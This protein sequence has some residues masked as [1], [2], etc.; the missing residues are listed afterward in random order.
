MGV[1]Y[2]PVAEHFPLHRLQLWCPDSVHL[3]DSDGM[4][5]LVQLLWDAASQ[6][7]APPPPRP[8]A[9]PRAP[10]RAG[11]APRLVV[12]GHAPVPRH[13]DP[14]EWS[15]VGQGGKAALP[16]RPSAIPSNPV[17]FSGAMLDAMEKVSPSSGSDGGP[18]V[19]P[20]GRTSRVVRRPAGVA[21]RRRGAKRQV[22]ATPS[23]APE[24]IPASRPSPPVPPAEAATQEVVEEVL[25]PTAGPVPA[26]VG[27]EGPAAC[28]ALPAERRL[29]PAAKCPVPERSRSGQSGV[30]VSAAR[31]AAVVDVGT[32]IR[33]Q[34]VVQGSFHQGSQRFSNAG[35]Q[36][37]SVAAF[38]LARHTLN[39]VFLWGRQDLDDVLVCGDALYTTA[40]SRDGFQPSSEFLCVTELPKQ[41]QVDEQVLEF[42]PGST[43]MGDLHVSEGQLIDAGV[44]YTLR[45]GLHT[46]FSQ[47]SMCMLTLGSNTTAV[48]SENGRF[49]VVDSHSRSRVGLLHHSGSSVLLQFACLDDLH[50]YIRRLADSLISGQQLFE[51][52]GI[53]VGG[54]AG[55]APSGVPLES[56]VSETSSAPAPESPEDTESRTP[57][58]AHTGSCVSES[59]VGV[60]ASPALSRISAESRVCEKSVVVPVERSQIVGAKSAVFPR[61]EPVKSSVLSVA[62]PAAVVDVRTGIRLLKVVQGS[63]HQGSSRFSNGGVQCMAIAAFSLARHTLNSVFSWGRQE[64]DDVLVLGDAFFTWVMGRPGFRPWSSFLS[65]TELPTQIQVD[66]QVLEFTHGTTVMGDLHVSE[67]HLIDAGVFYTLRNGL[68]TIF[69]QYSMCLLTMCANTTAIISENGRFAVVDSHPRSRVGLLHHSGSSVLLQFA[70]LDDLHHYIRRLADSLSSGQQLFELCGITV[71]GVQHCL[72]FLFRLLPVR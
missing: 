40:M 15:V 27:E 72:E 5:V 59:G 51:L 4:T 36:C 9:P 49:A 54:G 48:I 39:S 19:P 65:V 70:C 58:E 42:T 13:C 17:W 30:G 6:Q 57:A 62:G 68:L 1:P 69:S 45:N 11:A 63:F 20:A 50:H 47:Y 29:F 71:G 37:M 8:P 7:L 10:P 64:L 55:P 26:A 43:V 12:T 60:A 67:G 2:V 46:I 14:W 3:S 21:R 22:L 44:F 25:P 16:V 52:C 33:L 32:G 28:P 38:S 41:I 34:K 24:P 66:E 53:T 56:H 18:A 23:P 61:S 35:K 31:P